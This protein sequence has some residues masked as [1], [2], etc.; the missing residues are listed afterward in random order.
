[1]PV[2]PFC[3]SAA[4]R[5]NQRIARV[6]T[7]LATKLAHPPPEFLAQDAEKS[8]CVTLGTASELAEALASGRVTAERAVLAYGRR[9]LAAHA[10]T[11]CLTDVFLEEALAR[12]RHLDAEYQAT[13]KPVGKLHGLPISV[14]DMFCVAG[15]DATL[16]Y[17]AFIDQP[18][19]SN[20]LMV[21]ILLREG[22]IIIAKT[23]VPQMMLSFECSNPVIG[24]TVNPHNPKF[25]SGGSSG[26]EGALLA[27]RGAAIG[28]GTD[29]GGSLR[30]PAHFC[31]IYSLKPSAGRVPMAGNFSVK[32]GAENLISVAGPM[33][34]SVDDLQLFCESVLTDTH[35]RRDSAALPMPWNPAR[36]T[37]PTHRPLRIGFYTHDGFSAPVPAVIRA[38]RETAAALEVAS[39]TLI[40]FTVPDPLNM[41]RITYDLLLQDNARAIMKPVLDAKDPIEPSAIKL[42]RLLRLPQWVRSVLVKIMSWLGET[43]TAIFIHAMRAK[44][45]HDVHAT[46]AA[47]DRYRAAFHQQWTDL[48]LDFMICP[49]S[50]MVANPHNTFSDLAGTASH[51]LLYNLLDYATGIVPVTRVAVTDTFEQPRP[52][53]NERLH[54]AIYEIYDPAAMAGLPVGIQ[55]VGRRLDEERVVAAMHEV[56]RCLDKARGA[57]SA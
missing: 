18:S 55:V 35:L 27:L 31:G 56:V 43:R 30:L 17:S 44:S 6:R 8:Q 5:R 1:M 2:W 20:A 9:L 50:A 52:A 51:T 40:P 45:V 41:M 33:A 48:D 16:G 26:G 7:R 11:N 25:T 38:V 4:T 53:E 13:G 14:K 29:I 36:C 32:A 12:A 21:D 3:T 28:V 42:V 54:R 46:V 34:N 15:S 49:V 57:A 10:Q 47:R 24:R 23:N 19:A 37:L 39:H 22:A